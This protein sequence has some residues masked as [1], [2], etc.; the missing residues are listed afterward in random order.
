MENTRRGKWSDP[1]V[2]HKGW[3]CISMDDLGD[4]PD[5]WA[6]CEMCEEQ[7]IRYVHT[8]VHP[9][10]PD[11]MGCGSICAGH[12]EEDYESAKRRERQAKSRTRSRMRQMDK[13]IN[14]ET[15]K[16]SAS[17]NLYK[18]DRGIVTVVF[19]QGSRWKV[20]FKNSYFETKAFLPTEYQTAEEAIYKSFD[21]C[22]RF[23][24]RSN[25]GQA[26]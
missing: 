12:M 2:P 18:R 22:V 19:R 16:R 21:E 8:M 1:G 7:N 9:E 24:E 10:Y 6:V 11:R 5:D 3:E 15:W 26:W 17:G 23:R 20:M 13:W 14:P 25:N 4:N